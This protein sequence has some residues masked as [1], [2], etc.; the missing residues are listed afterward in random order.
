[1]FHQTVA[2]GGTLGEYVAIARRNGDEWF[3]GAMTSWE[4][5]EIEIDFSFLKDGKFKAEI[6]KDGINA[7]RNANDYKREVVEITSYT[8]MKVSMAP[9]GGWAARL[10]PVK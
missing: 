4:A 8:R 6:F 9:G 7:D 1:M 5:R 10:V 3:V 2:L